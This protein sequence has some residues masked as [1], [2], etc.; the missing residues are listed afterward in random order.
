MNKICMKYI[1]AVAMI[2]N[3]GLVSCVEDEG[4]YDAA[5]INEISISGID[6]N[7]SRIAYADSLNIKPE[8]LGTVSGTDES[9]LEYKWFFSE[10][11]GLKVTHTVISTE[12][13]LGIPV[14]YAP[15][16]YR[17]Y[18]QVTDKSTGMK[19]ERYT[20]LLASSPFVRGFYLFGDKE[21]GTCGMDFVSFIEGRDTSVINNIF[22]NSIKLKGARNLI[23]TGY[24]Y[25]AKVVNLWAIA[26]NGSYQVE[27]SASLGSF[28]VLEDRT[29]ENMIFATI[30]VTHPLK[31]VDVYAHAYGSNNQ[32][33]S[34][35]TRILLTENE[36]F[37]NNSLLY[38]IEAYDNPINRY[39]ASSEVLF[40]PAPYVF[41]PG[42][43]GYISRWM[44]FD[45]TNHCFV[46]LNSAYSNNCAKY[47]D[48][49]TPFYFD[50][51][52]YTPVRT[53]VYGENG[54][55]NAGRSYALMTD[56]NGK[57]YVYGFSLSSSTPAKYYGNEID[58]SVATGF[59]NASHYAFY[60]MQA[61]I[62]YSV[63]SQLWAYDYNRKDAKMLKDFGAE[64]TYLAMDYNSNN[65]PDDFI[66]A[67]YSQAEKGIVSK[68]SITDDQNKIEITP[69]EK[70]VWHTQLKV[71]K[72]EYRNSTI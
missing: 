16:N 15:G 22:V 45:E 9:Q 36:I 47:R 21:D 52:Q 62:L 51:T 28:D 30:P 1:M 41:Y 8:I 10:S 55:G 69:H 65:E 2:A 63:G 7:Y 6:E 48:S 64:I 42:N 72:V 66:V 24:H 20:N 43:S 23:F 29:G 70:E 5:T 12:R 46:G 58:L 17:L 35:R 50:Q 33:V 38:S 34:S 40:K 68:F 32:N 56:A 67:T 25:N 71:V 44:F 18:F 11:D 59:A 53:L 60:S 26:D 3:I 49:E 61:I 57:Y 19:Y 4:N 31:V 13:N 27:N 14:D 54:Y 37:K 39:S